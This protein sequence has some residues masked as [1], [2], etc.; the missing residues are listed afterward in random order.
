MSQKRYIIIGDGAAGTT[1]AQSLRATDK[2]ATIAILSDD[3]HAAYFRSA[4][5]NYLLGELR[6]EQI[7][8]VPPSFYDEYAIHRALVRVAQVDTKRGL[9]WLAQGG[10]PIG[11]DALV[12]AAGSRARPPTF[13]GAWLPGIMTMRTLQ[14]VHRVMDLIKLKGL[15][16]AVVVGGGPLA[17]EWAHGLSHRGVNVMIVVR[18]D[19][20]SVV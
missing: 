7:W 13:E 5:T 3:P 19:R 2:G 8:A 10:R 12:L 4:L 1:A 14:D 16:T 20:K 17:L 6:E 9:L 15:K 11:Y 18:E